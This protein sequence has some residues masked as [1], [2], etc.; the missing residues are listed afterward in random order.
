MT[1]TV[2]AQP[3]SAPLEP[4]PISDAPTVGDRIFQ[5]IV[6][7]GAW[8][9]V[10]LLGLIFVFLLQK[11]WPAITEVGFGN[12]LTTFEW[13]P[14]TVP[15]AYGIASVLVGTIVIAVVALVVAVPLAVGAALFVTEYLPPR[16][17]RPVTTMIDLLAAVPSLI[18]G[19]WGLYWLQPRL[20]GTSRWLTDHL[21]FIPIFDTSRP[22]FGSSMFVAWLVV[23]VM[24]LPI[25]ASVAREV[26]AQVPRVTCEGALALGGTRWGM[27]RKVVLP[28]G[29]SGIIGSAMLGLGRALGE[30]IA[31]VLI[32]SINF[33]VTPHILEPGGGSVAAL[34]ANQFPE[35]GENGRAALIAAGL[36]LFVVTLIV[37]MGARV[38]VNRSHALRSVDR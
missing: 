21:G 31:V 1:A 16:V 24:I 29:R 8:A 12:F 28:F 35:A 25:I 27:I 20:A 6:V 4:R 26:F 13:F 5:T 10:G 17:A 15:P 23:A 18:Y 34:I 36:A 19:M 3:R 14:D 22:V 38:V 11:A 33:Q 9:S 2:P 7:G 30:T 32:L 37:N